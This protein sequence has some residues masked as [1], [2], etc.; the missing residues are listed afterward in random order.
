MP[1]CRRTT[2]N[3]TASALTA[4]SSICAIIGLASI[5]RWKN[6]DQLYHN[7]IMS[8]EPAGFIQY[9]RNAKKVTYSVGI[10]MGKLGQAMGCLA[11]M[12]K[13][14]PDGPNTPVNYDTLLGQLMTTLAPSAAA[15]TLAA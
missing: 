9:L 13:G 7:Y 2:R 5:P 4:S 6:Y 8:M 11:M 1:A 10:S 15:E 3:I 12:T 14:N